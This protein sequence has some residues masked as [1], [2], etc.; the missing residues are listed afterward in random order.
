MGVQDV[1]VLRLALALLVLLKGV[2]ALLAEVV[3]GDTPARHGSW[4]SVDQGLE[5]GLPGASS[6]AQVLGASAGTAAQVGP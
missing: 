6:P 4:G 5:A 3:G 1:A 2:D